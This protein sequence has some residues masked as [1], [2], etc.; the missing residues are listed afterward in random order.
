[1]PAISE[2]LPYLIPQRTHLTLT[3][4]YVYQ[5]SFLIFTGHTALFTNYRN[6]MR[7]P[8]LRVSTYVPTFYSTGSGRVLNI[9]ASNNDTLFCVSASTN[10]TVWSVFVGDCAFQLVP[11]MSQ[12]LDASVPN[13]KFS[14]I[15]ETTCFGYSERQSAHGITQLATIPA[16]ARYFFTNFYLRVD[17]FW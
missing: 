14:N 5:L 10:N 2:R 8:T 1:M 15:S 4:S 16:I 12:I 11:I 6:S 7:N 9:R 13:A 3:M 17:I